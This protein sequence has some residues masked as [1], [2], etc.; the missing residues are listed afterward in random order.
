MNHYTLMQWVDFARGVLPAELRGAMQQHLDLPCEK[1]LDTVGFWQAVKARALKEIAPRPPEKTV[2]QAKAL[3]GLL[4]HSEGRPWHLRLAERIFDSTLQPAQAGLRYSAMRIGRH[5]VYRSGDCLLDLR[6]DVRSSGISMVGQVVS[7]SNPA[8]SY[9]GARVVLWD[10]LSLA[11]TTSN[12]LGEF[13]L[14]TEASSVPWVLVEI[15]EHSTMVV[16]LPK[17][18]ESPSA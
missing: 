12:E 17:L 3:F 16:P 4:K 1:C 11:E 7:A 14:E 10:T 9:C 18:L 5:M 2:N 15:P 6:L 8:V 13:M